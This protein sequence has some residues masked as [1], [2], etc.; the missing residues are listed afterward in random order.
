MCG[1]WDVRAFE[2]CGGVLRFS[3]SLAKILQQGHDIILKLT[4]IAVHDLDTIL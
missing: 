4:Y 3:G 2:V 1:M